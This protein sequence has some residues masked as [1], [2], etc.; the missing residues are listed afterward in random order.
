M[1][2]P[3]DRFFAERSAGQRRA[4]QELPLQLPASLTTVPAAPC[5]R[6]S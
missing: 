6:S 2:F 1:A 5:R 3:A 4:E